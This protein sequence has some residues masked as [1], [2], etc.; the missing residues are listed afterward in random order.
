MIE[1]SG[2]A[3]SGSA[4]A[5]AGAA[6]DRYHV[7]SVDEKASFDPVSKPGPTPSIRVVEA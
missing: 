4:I 7:H 5:T 1:I 2:S 3:G 6:G